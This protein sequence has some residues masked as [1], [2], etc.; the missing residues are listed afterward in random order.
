[1]RKGTFGTLFSSL[2]AVVVALGTVYVSYT[3]LKEP[4]NWLD[5]MALVFTG[6]TAGVIAYFLSWG[7]FQKEPAPAR[8]CPNCGSEMENVTGF[9]DVAGAIHAP[10]WKKVSEHFKCKACG[11]DNTDP[12]NNPRSMIVKPASTE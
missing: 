9:G 5:W 8:Y 4:Q 3:K 2:L 7:H 1:M 10:L 12:N 6:L 11:W